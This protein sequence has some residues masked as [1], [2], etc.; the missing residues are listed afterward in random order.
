[1]GKQ[2]KLRKAQLRAAAEAI[3]ARL[4]ERARTVSGPGFIETYGEL[5]ARYRDRIEAYR[6][7][8]LRAPEDWRCRLRVRAPE[9]RFLDLVKFAF[10]LYPVPRH[11]ENAW[12]NDLPGEPP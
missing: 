4:R 9:A 8:A 6:A 3:S 1:M 5:P 7:S 11:L 2:I 10:A 12:L